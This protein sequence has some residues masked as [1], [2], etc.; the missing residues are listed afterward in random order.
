MCWLPTN[1]S[2]SPAP[3][4]IAT[5]VSEVM[6]ALYA[7]KDIPYKVEFVHSSHN[8]PHARV[9][10]SPVMLMEHVPSVLMDMKYTKDTVYV[11]S[12]I[13]WNA[14]ETNSVKFVPSPPL[15]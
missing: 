12:K 1:A 6:F 14:K 9:I 15:D 5:I 4:T 8:Q 13:V 7:K 3:S 2:P 10:V 11:T